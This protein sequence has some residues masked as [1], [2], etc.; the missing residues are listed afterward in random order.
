[1]KKEMSMENSRAVSS[2]VARALRKAAQYG[3][4]YLTVWELRQVYMHVE[5]KRDDYVRDLWNAEQS[6][7][8]LIQNGR[9][10]LCNAECVCGAPVGNAAIN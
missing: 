7:E 3:R 2:P 5:G 1:M 4:S 8:V 10:Y 9:I 6:G